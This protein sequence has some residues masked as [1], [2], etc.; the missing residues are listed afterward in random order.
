MT[1][2][3]PSKADYQ[4]TKEV[5]RYSSFAIVGAVFAL[6]LAASG[7]GSDGKDGASCTVTDNGDGT[8]T[9]TCGDSTVTVK[10]GTDGKDGAGCKATDNGDGTKTIACDDGTTVTVSNGTNCTVKDN[11]DNTKTITCTDGTSVTVENGTVGTPGK[12]GTPGTPGN[13]GGNVRITDNHGTDHLLSSGEYATAGKKFVTATI[14]AATADAA[15]KATV[16]FKVEDADKKPI[17]DLA[18]CSVS[19]VRLVP[20]D[21]T[22]PY[23]QWVSYIYVEA[24]AGTGEWNNAPWNRAATEKVLNASRESSSAGTLTNNG[25][26]T[27]KYELKADLS[28]AVGPAGAVTYTAADRALTHRISVMMGGHAGATATAHY[29]FVPAGGAVTVTRD[30]IKTG[31]CIK[32][33]G[34]E[35]HGHGG[36][37]LTMEN[38]VTCH[39]PGS[40]DA[41]GGETLDMAPMIHKIHAGGELASIPGADGNAWLTADNGQYVI[42]GH[43]NTKAT[44]WKVGFPAVLQNC[45]ACHEGTGANVDNW[46]TVPSRMACASCHDNLNTKS[47]SHATRT[48]ATCAGCHPAT[49]SAEAVVDAHDWTKKDVRNTSEFT[50]EITMDKALYVAGDKPVVTIVLKDRATG[51]VIDH[52]GDNTTGYI[53]KTGTATGCDNPAGTACP[54]NPNGFGDSSLYVV[55]PRSK[56][57]PVL[58]YSARAKVLSTTVGPF[59]L[60]GM[61]ATDAL[62]MQIDSGLD[63]HV[64]DESTLAGSIKVA[65]VP[66]AF[67]DL[68][69]AT[70]A[71]VVAWLNGN[72]A[73]KARAIAYIDEASNKVGI[74]SRGLGNLYAVQLV[75]GTINTAIFN[76]TSVNLPGS[77]N[78]MAKG[79]SDPKVVRTA[80]NVKYTLDAVDDLAPGTY[81]VSVQIANRYRS[82]SNYW[83]PTVGWKT[84]QVKTATEEKLIARNCQSCHQNAQGVGFVLDFPRHNKPFSDDAADMCGGCHDYQNGSATSANWSS[85]N[86]ISR[87]VHAIHYGSS[88]TYRLETVA[89]ED[90]GPAEREWDISLP[91]DVRHCQACHPDGT[92]SGTWK[93]N[94]SRLACMGCHDSDAAQ[95]HFKL[96]TLDPTPMYPFNGD[97]QESCKACH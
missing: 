88:L 9:I 79:T 25:D 64:G 21:A 41:Q 68:G 58:T 59:V 44:W 32:C 46:K 14:T 93:T 23:A 38:C 33:H 90:T 74:R 54:I 86:P 42:W 27:Y 10:N 96:M 85:G 36:D 65:F 89:H 47:P 15:G 3:R 55:G 60:T 37:R 17:T 45:T 61:T 51:A 84:F 52:S 72:A 40:L 56:R 91:Q 18:S 13:S 19:L 22:R 70:A 94:P 66:T 8:Q 39:L 20:K 87:R 75:A 92:T 57:M 49:G 4:R 69:A 11:G 97:E 5:M 1:V 63:V 43:S 62:E 82:G 76:N 24:T 34:P 31:T 53:F 78:K 48:D 35:F 50:V 7:C 81:V 12:P 67:A 26:G 95:V 80:A 2:N 6:T 16:E 83:T 29:D 30:I 28:K 77:S 73:F 71:E